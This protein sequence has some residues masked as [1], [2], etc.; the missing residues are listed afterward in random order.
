MREEHARWGLPYAGIDPRMMDAEESEYAKADCITV[1]SHF[2][3]RSFL[4]QGVAPEKTAEMITLLRQQN[5]W[6][7]DA[8]VLGHV[9]QSQLKDV[10]SRSHVMVPV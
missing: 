9:S 3:N 10:M 7:E 8:R 5:L 4:S 6:P 2:A 1:P